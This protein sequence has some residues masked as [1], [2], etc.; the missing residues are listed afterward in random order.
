MMDKYKEKFIK[1]TKVLM[2]PCCFRLRTINIS[3][4]ISSSSLDINKTEDAAIDISIVDKCD[5]CGEEVVEATLD[6]NIAEIVQM[7]NKKGYSTIF[8]CGSHL[9]ENSE[10]NHIYI[11]FRSDVRDVFYINFINLLLNDI[12]NELIT[13]IRKIKLDIFCNNN[14]S[15]SYYAEDI[16]DVDNAIKV[17]RYIASNIKRYSSPQLLEGV[18]N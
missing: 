7:F 2:C 6:L 3:S 9:F 4:V 8:S 5:E 18:D 12:P 11:A 10:D 15:I 16:N 13:Y 14:I 17:F 1:Q